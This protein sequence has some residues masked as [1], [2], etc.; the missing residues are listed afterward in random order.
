MEN[1]YD[2]KKFTFISGGVAL[3]TIALLAIVMSLS[4][5]K[6]MSRG[7][8]NSASITVSGVGEITAAPDIATVNFTIRE[9]AKTVPEAQKL[10][11]AKM[12]KALS[13]LSALGIDK[14]DTKTVSYTVNPKYESQAT[15]C[16]NGYCPVGKTTITGYE[17]SESV[18]VKVRKIEKAGD[19]LGAL[20]AINITEISGPE[21]TVDDINKANADAKAKAIAD[22]RSKA[23]ATAD[24]LGV[25]LGSITQ[26]SEDNGGYYPVAYGMG[27]SMKSQAMD[28]VSVPTG[29]SVIKAHVSVTYSVN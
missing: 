15:Y 24:A 21:F 5:W 27:A 6:T 9:S 23:K 18:Q 17:I 20:G 28:S 13:S 11:E 22:A 26:Y 7:G 12:V 25:S 2:F 19:V 4:E 16:T 10:A 14:K 1:N 29:E 8:S 3:I